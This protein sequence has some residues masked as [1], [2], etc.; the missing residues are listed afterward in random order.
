MYHLPREHFRPVF[1]DVGPR[2]GDFL[3]I[4]RKD[5]VI[6]SLPRNDILKIRAVSRPKLMEHWELKIVLT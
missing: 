5:G 6:L 3:V 2:L 4:D 1:P